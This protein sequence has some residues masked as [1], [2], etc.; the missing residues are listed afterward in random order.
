LVFFF[1][2]DRTNERKGNLFSVF[3]FSSLLRKEPP[4]ER[5]TKTKKKKTKKK[6]ADRFSP[7]TREKREKREKK[8]GL[9]RGK[10]SLHLRANN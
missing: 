4:R 5:K 8:I 2:R 3:F 7:K 10:N 1:E 9:I 6:S